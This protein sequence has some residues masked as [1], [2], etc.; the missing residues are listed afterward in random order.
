MAVVRNMY[1]TI[2][3]AVDVANKVIFEYFP[4]VS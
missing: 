3:A 4:T 2:A 1:H